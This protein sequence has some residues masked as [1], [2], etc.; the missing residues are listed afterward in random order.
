MKLRKGFGLVVAALAL[1]VALAG[2]G[3]KEKEGAKTAEDEFTLTVWTHPFVGTE[4]KEEQDQV[5]N[6]MA[7]D[8]KKEYPKAKIAFEEIPWAN[9]EQK[10]MT[11]LSS[12][13]GPDVFY[14]IPDMMTQFA[15]KGILEPLDDHLG[16]DFDAAD[17]SETSL[18]AVTYE[19]KKYGLPI[20]REVQTMF[21]NTDILKEIG[22]DPEKLPET[23]EDFDAL[24]AKAKEK[25]YYGR[26]FEGGSTLNSTLY[27]FIWQAGGDV[28]KNN[29]AVIDSPEAIEAFTEIKKLYDDG[30]I[31]KDSIN[32]TEQTAFQEGKMLAAY[33]TGYLIT[34]MAEQ[35]KDNYVIGAPL[36]HKEQATF[37]TTGMF[38]VASTSKNKEAAAKFVE[39]MTNSENMQEFCKLT[40]YIPARTSAQVIFDDNERM[41]ELAQYVEIANPGVI[42]PSARIFMPNVQ[43]KLQAMLEGSLSPA[44]AAKEA[45]ELIQNEMK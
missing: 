13:D 37:G 40:N 25:G 5:F 35:G 9:R 11:A 6:K 18:E 34:S 20:L 2:C 19:Q 1:S 26:T 23:W 36:K 7:D 14:L 4:L 29:K 28:V 45:N 24:A 32:A 43:A 21:Y 27:P 31:P 17:F 16:G 44:E 39:V 38:S 30:I 8:F 12:S 42:H 3:S 33:G 22:G 10:I 41:K 15:D